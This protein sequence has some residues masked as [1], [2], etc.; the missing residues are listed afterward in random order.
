MS[1]KLRPVRELIIKDVPR[2]FLGRRRS[3]CSL[4]IRHSSE[5]DAKKA[6]SIMKAKYPI[7]KMVA[8]RCGLHQCWHIAHEFDYVGYKKKKMQK[9]YEQILNVLPLVDGLA[10]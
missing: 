5:E 9:D 4:K 8:H 7:S 3:G 2:E 10:A 1:I 6:I